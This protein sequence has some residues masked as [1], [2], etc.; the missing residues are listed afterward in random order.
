VSRC[1]S[2]KGT[3]S[4]FDWG[5]ITRVYVPVLFGSDQS[6][7]EWLEPFFSFCPEASIMTTHPKLSSPE[8]EA[9]TSA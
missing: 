1:T 3:I 7:G 9:C 5:P 4:G 2:H 8:I 6:K